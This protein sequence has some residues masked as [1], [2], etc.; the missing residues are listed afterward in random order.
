MTITCLVE[1]LIPGIMLSRERSEASPL[2]PSVVPV[3]IPSVT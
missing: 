2:T 1:P 3:G